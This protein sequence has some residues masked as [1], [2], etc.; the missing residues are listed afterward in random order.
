[1]VQKIKIKLTRKL[2][3]KFVFAS[4][5][6]PN[7]F[8]DYEN[9]EILTTHYGQGMGLIYC[10]NKN[11]EDGLLFRFESSLDSEAKVDETFTEI[12]IK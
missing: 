3:D 7:K 10:W 8:E 1:M 4:N 9:Y 12:S 2:L 6:T 11:K 5:Q